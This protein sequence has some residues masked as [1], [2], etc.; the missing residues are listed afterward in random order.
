MVVILSITGGC[1]NKAPR[2]AVSGR[3]T[4]DGA[5]IADGSIAFFPTDGS[6]GPSSGGNIENGRYAIAA[7]QGVAIGA[8]RV[9]IHAVRK[10][11]KQVRS[12]SQPGKLIDEVT[13]AVPPRYHTKSEL[14]VDVKPGTNTFDF[15]LAS[16]KK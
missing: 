13:E 11:G 2:A 6:A 8:N 5:P 4:L 1:A 3:V 10:T 7:A 14:K 12:V 9:E 15:E 16:K